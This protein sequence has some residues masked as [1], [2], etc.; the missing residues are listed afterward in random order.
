MNP[1]VKEL[2]EWV[3]VLGVLLIPIWV[4]SVSNIS[5]NMV[6]TESMKP[7]IE[8]SD[9]VIATP[10]DVEVGDIV[11]FTPQVPGVELPSFVHRVTGTKKDGSWITQGDGLKFPDSAHVTDEDIHGVVRYIIPTRFL[12]STWTVVL[13]GALMGAAVMWTFIRRSDK[14]QA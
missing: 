10:G 7:T 3:V 9:L 2:L 12:N 1:K 4:L 11:V 5:I 6:R 8:R 13:G 14:G